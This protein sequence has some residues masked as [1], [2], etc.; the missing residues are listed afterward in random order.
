MTPPLGRRKAKHTLYPPPYPTGRFRQRLPY[1][2][3]DPEN[4]FGAQSRNGV[5][6]NFC[7]VGFERR[8]PLLA[9]LFVAPGLLHGF[10]ELLDTFTEGWL[11]FFVPRFYRIPTSRQFAAIDS[12]FG[13]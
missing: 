1:G 13:A 2:I 3:Q 8:A 4:L 7:A 11:V 6:P 9:V 10:E 12:S 5:F